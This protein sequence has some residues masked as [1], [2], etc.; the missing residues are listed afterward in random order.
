MASYTL[1]LLPE[2]DGSGFTVEVPTLPGVVTFGATREE[3]IAMARE[4]IDL[5]LETARDKGWEIPV[6]RLSPELTRIDVTLLSD[7]RKTG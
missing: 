7:L 6:E 4:A 1:L 3:A 2:T 5:Y